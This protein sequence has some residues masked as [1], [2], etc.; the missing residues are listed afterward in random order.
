MA[1]LAAGSI[2]D[3]KVMGS[4][5]AGSKSDLTQAIRKT[6]VQPKIQCTLSTITQVMEVG[7]GLMPNAMGWSTVRRVSC[8]LIFNEIKAIAGPFYN[9]IKVMMK[10]PNKRS[11]N[12]NIEWLFNHSIFRVELTFG[13]G[14]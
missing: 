7:R 11:N 1:E 9:F 13:R 4:N 12:F 10:G 8:C 14:Q 3:R 5:P 2:H 6:E